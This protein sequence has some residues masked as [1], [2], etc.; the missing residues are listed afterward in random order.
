MEERYQLKSL[1]LAAKEIRLVKLIHAGPEATSDPSYR[2]R[3]IIKHVDFESEPKYQ[4]LSYMWGPP[5]KTSEIYIEDQIFTIRIN[6]WSFLDQ[7]SRDQAFCESTWLWIDQICI[8]Q[9]DG[10]ERTHQV[11]QMSEIYTVAQRVIIWLGV[12]TEETNRVMDDIAAGL[13]LWDDEVGITIRSRVDDPRLKLIASLPYWSRLWIIQEITLARIIEV[14]WGSRQIPWTNLVSF[15]R[16]SWGEKSGYFGLPPWWLGFFDGIYFRIEPG[17][18]ALMYIK[19]LHEWPDRE[20]N[21]GRH[22]RGLVRMSGE[23]QC[24]DPRDRVYGMLGL[25]EPFLAIPADYS[26]TTEQIFWL[27]LDIES[28]NWKPRPRLDKTEWR[29]EREDFVVDLSNALRVPLSWRMRPKIQWMFVM[30]EYRRRTVLSFLK[31]Q[32]VFYQ[33][34]RLQRPQ[35]WKESVSV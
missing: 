35:D 34:L 19:E 25:S 27:I 21:D 2:P 1:N 33:P 12:G 30:E 24:E 23:T 17:L 9:E 20:S 3:C 28:R 29:G 7:Q 32:S 26:L 11:G 14:V 15:A 18:Y 31:R 4:A 8:N 22:W 10:Q 13:D 16:H 5:E 6:L